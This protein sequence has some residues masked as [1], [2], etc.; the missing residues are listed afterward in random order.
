MTAGPVAVV[1]GASSRL[2]IGAAIARRLAGAGWRLLLVAE[3]PASEL[4]AVAAECA[5]LS[6]IT[7]GACARVADLRDADAATAMIEAAVSRFGRV[8]ALVNNAAMRVFKPIGA[9]TVAEFDQTVAVNLRAP[10]LASQA[11]LPVMRRQGGGRILNVA[12]QLG[13]VTFPTRGLYGM[14]KAGLIHLTKTMALELAPE[15]ITV[16]AISPGPV[17]TAPHIERA[18]NDPSAAAE[19][20][21]YI[22]M[23]RMGQ[24]EEIGEIAFLL[25][26]TSATFLTGHD[27]I[28]DGGYTLH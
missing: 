27:L 26:T 28:V 10:F 12:S 16:N 2:G 11:V 23:G 7:D 15:N 9:F 25:L 1:T 21:R 8:D 14:T 22:P 19:R 5:G 24:P 13:S 6:G 4:D 3:G 20:L 17:Q 18:K